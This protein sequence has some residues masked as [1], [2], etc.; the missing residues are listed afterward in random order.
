MYLSS[1]M[2]VDFHKA[3]KLCTDS[4]FALLHLSC[5]ERQIVERKAN[6]V[7]EGTWLIPYWA[8]RN[9]PGLMTTYPDS[10]MTTR[11]DVTPESVLWR[12]I[13]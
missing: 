5:I 8:T 13:K 1:V 12:K 6:S 9:A 7:R 2:T 10:I 4:V 11:D 3:Q